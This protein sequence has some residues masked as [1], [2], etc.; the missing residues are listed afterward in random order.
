MQVVTD[1]HAPGLVRILRQL[2][3][4]AGTITLRTAAPAGPGAS[5][6]TS[7]PCAATVACGTSDTVSEGEPSLYD[8][9]TCWS[10]GCRELR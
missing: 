9:A 2:R 6:S 10:G 1:Q 5:V 8:E 4:E 7:V 3:L